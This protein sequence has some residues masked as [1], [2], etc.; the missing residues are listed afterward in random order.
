MLTD[1]QI[2]LH[3][4][5]YPKAIYNMRTATPELHKLEFSVS[6]DYNWDI[7]ATIN[8]YFYSIKFT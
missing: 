6:H 5:A 2:F 1:T 4:T 8:N 3:L 7:L